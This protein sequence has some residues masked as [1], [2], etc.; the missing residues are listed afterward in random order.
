[1]HQHTALD[2]RKEIAVQETWSGIVLTINNFAQTSQVLYK[3]W[4]DVT[5]FHSNE[6]EHSPHERFP[7]SETARGEMKG[8]GAYREKR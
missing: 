1:M 8:E 6:K 4:S 7:R 5:I 2:S 3:A